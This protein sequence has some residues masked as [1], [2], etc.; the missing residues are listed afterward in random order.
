MI[1]SYELP[2]FPLHTVLFPGQ[3]LP[4]H[5][6]EP[7]YR[8]MMADCLQGERTFGVT[9]IRE[10]V[11]VGGAA[12]PCEVGTSAT[13][14]EVE[15]L[16]DGRMNV[17]TVG[18]ERFRLQGYETESKPYLVGRVSPWP[19]SD[20]ALPGIEVQ[21]AVQRRL[22]HYVDLLSQASD[23]DISLVSTP[24][25][26]I[27]LAILAAVVLQVPQE[28]KQTLLELPS[29]S[30]LLRQLDPLLRQ[31]NRAL[32]IVLASSRQGKMDGPFSQ[33]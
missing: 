19:W 13:I 1:E 18:R 16:S 17:I 31:E 28:Q 7:R 33:N 8:Q 4:L 15:R 23:A 6:F 10:G 22:E 3:T 20:Y 25:S 26:P 14:E 32:E 9:L 30:E 29:V 5:I 12:T 24:P 27:D 11:E 2:L 21:R